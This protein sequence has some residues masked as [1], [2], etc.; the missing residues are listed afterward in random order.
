MTLGKYKCPTFKMNWYS[1][2]VML[3]IILALM[4]I[5]CAPYS[6]LKIFLV[7]LVNVAI[8]A[9][10]HAR[11]QLVSYATI[12]IVAHKSQRLNVFIRVS[13][14]FCTQEVLQNW[15][16]YYRNPIVYLLSLH[17]SY[18]G[19]AT[20]SRNSFRRN[21]TTWKKTRIYTFEQMPLVENMREFTPTGE[22]LHW[23][24]DG[25]S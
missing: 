25:K 4:A 19:V 14:I 8:L 7:F 2:F 23:R 5:L 11:H 20:T 1:S 17:Q 15:N 3:H 22:A 16:G 12:G 6:N 21:L 10:K 18:C 24:R 13:N 9:T